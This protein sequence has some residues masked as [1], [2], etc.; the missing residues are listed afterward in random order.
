[1]GGRVGV[2]VGEVKKYFHNSN[3]TWMCLYS[4]K[5]ISHVD[6]VWIAHMFKGIVFTKEISVLLVLTLFQ[7]LY[8]SVEHKKRTHFCAV[9]MNRDSNNDS[10]I[11]SILKSTLHF[12]KK[13]NVGTT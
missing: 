7:S 11:T 13:K 2:R 8:F 6:C 10:S 9:T 3:D 5:D 1:M 4:G 12:M